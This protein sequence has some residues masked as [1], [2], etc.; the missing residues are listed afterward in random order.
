[1]RSFLHIAVVWAL[2][3]AGADVSG[4]TSGRVTRVAGDLVYLTGLNGAAPIWSRLEVESG[5]GVGAQLEVI[6]ELEGLLVA[7][8]L[9]TGTGIE[10]GDTV[11]LRQKGAPESVTKSRRMVHATRVSEGPTING[12]LDDAAW[13]QA[14]PVQGF[15]QRDPNYW[16]PSSEETV[17]LIVYDEKSLYFGFECRLPDSSGAVVANNMRRDSDIFGDDNIQIMLDTYN[18]RQNGFFFFVNPLGAQSDLMLSNEG[19]SYNLDWDCNWTSKTQRYSDRWTVEVEIPFSQLR[20]KETDEMVWGIN[21]ARYNARKNEASQLVVGLQSSSSTERYRMSDIGELRGLQRVQAKRPVQLKPYA[22]PG[23]SVDYVDPQGEEDPT[24]ETGIDLRYGLTSNLSLDVSYNTD[25]AQ[26]E[27]DQEQTNL[28]QFRLFFPEK[29]EFFLE[30]ANLFEFG[31]RAVRTGGGTRPPTLLFYSR[32]IGLE[33]GQKI[34]IILGT[35][36]AGKEGRTSVGALNVVTNSRTFL[37]DGDTVSVN[38]TNYS[39]VALRRDVFSK[40]NVGVM[41]VN[42]QIDDPTEGWGR[43]NRAVGVDFNYSPTRNLNFQAF[44]ARTFDSEIDDADDARFA[45]MNYRGRDYWARL[46]FLEVEDQFEPAVGF[47][48]RRGDLDAFRRYDVY[49]RARPR[50]NWRGVRYL[51]IGPELQILTDRDNNV[52]FW[53]AELSWFTSFNTGDFWSVQ[54]E[55]T[56]DIVDEAFSPSD[57]RDD[58]EIPAGEYTFT[59]VTTGPRPSRSRKFRP[60]FRFEAGS[61]YTGKRYTFDTETVFLPSGKFTFEMNYE[62]NWI[63]LPQGNFSIHTLSNRLLYSF[64]TDFFVKLFVQWNNDNE[65]VGANFLLNYRYRPG[66]DVFFVFDHGYDTFDG[67]SRRN[68]SVLVKWSYLLNL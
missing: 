28:T 67:L 55:T 7:R 19:R 48:N 12:H 32:R 51:S 54:S 47:V 10:T 42:K 22:L 4:A 61:F 30:G 52:K 13:A 37:D 63:R 21:L 60:G 14:I 50:P 8:V 5:G 49:L 35:K 45:M 43:F 24:F 64:S 46:K 53:T 57:R 27:G 11:V 18:D 34:P 62:G 38:R 26:V 44:T 40:S 56:H 9:A 36:V 17:A 68:R 15:V 31:E 20:F 29:R 3:S 1:M 33:E 41:V 25:F 16:L 39:V 6:K 58:I 59:T 23:T 65:S 66:S 2:L